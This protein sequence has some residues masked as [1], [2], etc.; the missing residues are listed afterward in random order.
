MRECLLV[1]GRGFQVVGRGRGSW[2]IDWKGSALARRRFL[3]IRSIS[4]QTLSSLQQQI[5]NTRFLSVNSRENY[6][7]LHTIDQNSEICITKNNELI[8]KRITKLR[9]SKWRTIEEGSSHRP[10]SAKRKPNKKALDNQR[11]KKSDC[12]QPTD[13]EQ[14]TPAKPTLPC[15]PLPTPARSKPQFGTFVIGLLQYQHPSMKVCYGCGGEL[16]PSGRIPDPPNDLI[17]VSGDCYAA[18]CNN[19]RKM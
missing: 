15:V 10:P 13:T 8:I 18:K 11:I 2:V 3:G 17:I 16:K 4:K 1:V 14:G 9:A 7:I 5:I 12:H 19:R 6:S